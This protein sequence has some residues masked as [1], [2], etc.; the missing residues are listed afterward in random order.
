[1]LIIDPKLE[2]SNF[3]T[4]ISEIE[5]MLGNI[6]KKDD[7]G[8]R[9]LSYPINKSRKGKYVNIFFEQDPSK[10]SEIKS[11]LKINKKVLRNL[12]I[13][14]QKKW[15][16]KMKTTKNMDTSKLSFIRK[17]FNRL[18]RN[19]NRGPKRTSTTSTSSRKESETNVK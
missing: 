16:Y 1:M 4:L 10:I 6:I 2:D 11:S 14:H 9:D 15:P 8:S 18:G 3:D 12:I 19:F 13:V 7:L 5:K 17:P